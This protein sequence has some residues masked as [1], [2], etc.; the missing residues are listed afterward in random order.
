MTIAGEPNIDFEGL[1]NARDVGGPAAGS[2][3]GPDVRMRTGVLF[4]SETPEL[5]TAADVARATEEFGIG[6]VIDLRGELR[7]GSGSLGDDGR[8]VIMDFFGLAGG[9]GSIDDSADGFLPSLLDHGAAPLATFLRLFVETDATVLVHCHTGKDRTGFIIAMTLALV[10]VADADIVA[11][12]ERSQPV[13]DAMIDNLASA[14]RGVPA[15]APEYARHPPSTAT[16][17]ALLARLRADWSSPLAWAEEHGIEADLVERV[18]VR[19][20]GS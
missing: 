13:F 6:R 2:E 9:I 16:I 19:L 12:Y 10:G 17:T 7:G 4:R 1:V 20:T 15:D 14:G 18:R 11:D 5:M 8:G 3:R